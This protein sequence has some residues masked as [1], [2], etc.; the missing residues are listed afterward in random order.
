MIQV[1]Q[2]TKP[3]HLLRRRREEMVM[4]L[5]SR[6]IVDLMYHLLFGAIKYG[7]G[8]MLFIGDRHGYIITYTGEERYAALITLTLRGTISALSQGD[9]S[10]M[11]PG[12][13]KKG[14]SASEEGTDQVQRGGMEDE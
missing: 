2:T 5:L 11:F 10:P 14:T 6:S 1:T 7:F 4:I 3:H 13:A 12:P 8:P 9:S